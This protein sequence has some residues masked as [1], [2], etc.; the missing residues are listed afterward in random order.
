[1][2]LFYYD[3]FGNKIGPISVSVLKSLA[4]SGTVKPETM[5]ETD[6]GQMVN[7]RKISGM[8]F[9]SKIPVPPI[10]YNATKIYHDEESNLNKIAR[11]SSYVLCSIMVFMTLLFAIAS[12][13][14]IEQHNIERRLIAR[15]MKGIQSSISG[16]INHNQ[17]GFGTVDDIV[18]SIDFYTLIP[19]EEYSRAEMCFAYI[20][21]FSLLSVI[22][23]IMSCFFLM[24]SSKFCKKKS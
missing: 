20:I 3:D 6:E 7:A 19:F 4:E 18:S 2:K 12:M 9:I 21:V 14:M 1:M 10:V 15:G 22:C 13:A 5:V 16:Y 23:S 24:L 8:K 11:I 17:S